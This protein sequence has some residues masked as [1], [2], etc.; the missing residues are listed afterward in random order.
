MAVSQRP[1]ALSNTVHE[2]LNLDAQR[3][4]QAE[5]WGPHVAR[6]VADHHLVAAAISRV[7]RDAAVVD[8]DL[9]TGLDVVVDDH[10]LVTAY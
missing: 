8:L 5:S 1:T 10:A 4:G 9:L 7:Q 2:V 6:P 3:L